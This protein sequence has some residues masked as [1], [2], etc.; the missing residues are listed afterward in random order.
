MIFQAETQA[1]KISIESTPQC[2]KCRSI[3]SSYN[4]LTSHISQKHPELVG[5]GIE[6]EQLLEG[7]DGDSATPFHNDKAVEDFFRDNFVPTRN[8]ST[9]LVNLC[10]KCDRSF[11]TAID[12]RVHIR[13]VH[14]GGITYQGPNSIEKVWLE[15]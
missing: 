12:V 3:S 4:S 14:F 5:T 2:P 10:T 13:E 8:S 1:K 6:Y 11:K 15:F 9:E 7:G